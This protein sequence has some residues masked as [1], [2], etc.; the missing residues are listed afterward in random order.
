MRHEKHVKS[1]NTGEAEIKLGW[2]KFMRGPIALRRILRDCG[3]DP[4]PHL[5]PKEGT[6]GGCSIR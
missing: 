1:N 6:S 2:R 5:D 4:S 3:Y